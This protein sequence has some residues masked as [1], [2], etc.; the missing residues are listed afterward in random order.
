[1]IEQT[2]QEVEAKYCMA[3]GYGHDAV[4]IYGD[5][6]SV[7][8]N[9]GVKTVEEAMELG[10]DAAAYVSAKF[11]KPIKLEFEK[12][13]FPYLLINKKRY[14]GLYFTRPDKYDKMD[15]KGIETVRRDNCPLVANMMNTCLQKLLINRL[16]DQISS[17]KIDPDGAVAYAK[18]VIADLLCNRIDISQLVITKELAK[19]DYAAKQAH[20]ELAN[21]MKKRDPGTAPKLGDRVPY[22]LI[23]AAK[24]TPAYMKAEVC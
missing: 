9:F 11:V 5:T 7:M 12:V 20:V 16:F 13:Y 22:V 15:C 17:K 14:A 4:V 8:V 18:Q 21:K 1:M 6:D 3:Q 10:K 24:G 23:A 19:Q 2:K